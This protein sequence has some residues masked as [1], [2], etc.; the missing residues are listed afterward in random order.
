M[1]QPAAYKK[2]KEAF[3]AQFGK[4]NV[5]FIKI[6]GSK[7]QE[8]GLPDVIVLVHNSSSDYFVKTSSH[9]WI[10][11]KRDWNDTPTALQQYNIV[12]LRSHGYQT[13]YYIGTEFKLNWG[14]A[15][16]WNFSDYLGKYFRKSI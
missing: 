4:E 6:H 5:R 15:L 11:I 9:F 13:G 10:E 14:D 1:K 12:N 8:A 16:A 2:L 3:V 7:Y